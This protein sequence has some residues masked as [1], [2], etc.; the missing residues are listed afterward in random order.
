[1]NQLLTNILNLEICFVNQTTDS[2]F[3]QKK[4]RGSNKSQAQMQL[5]RDNIDEYGFLDVGF[6]GSLYAWQKHFADGHSIWEVLDRGLA[7]NDWLMKF[8][9]TRIHHIFFDSLDHCP[10]WIVLDGLEV[11]TATKPFRFKEMWLSD[12]RCSNVVEAV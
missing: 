8:F 7:T 6:V 2:I 9:G 3:H 10:L 1:M 12:P 11:A 4:V 5:F